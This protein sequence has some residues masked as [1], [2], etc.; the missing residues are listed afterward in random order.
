MREAQASADALGAPLTAAYA[1]GGIIRAGIYHDR[2][3]DPDVDRAVADGIERTRMVRAP[4]AELTIRLLGS[5]VQMLKGSADVYGRCLD[6]F[7]ELDGLGSSWFVEMGA[8]LVGLAAELAE[9][10]TAAREHTV[11]YIRSCRQSGIRLMLPC[12]IRSSARLVGAG[13]PD[14]ALRLWGG[15][16]Q[17]EVIT[18]LR[19][20]PLMERLDDPIRQV[21][22]NELAGGAENL[23]LEGRSWSVTQVT[24]AA[25]Q[26]LLT[27]RPETAG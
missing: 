7:T 22:T 8:Q 6:T 12:A 21:C 16:E 3:D 24:E 20:L 19:N 4:M 23:L 11:R 15:A 27:M 18:G 13:S 17:M 25:E 1:M 14:L 10:K 5:I 9:D 2:C 26:A